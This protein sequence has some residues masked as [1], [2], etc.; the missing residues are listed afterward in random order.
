MFGIGVPELLLILAIALIV[1]G[2]K[3]L[4]DLA[5]SMGRAM[6]EFKKATGEI[7]ESLSMD[8]DLNDVKEAFDDIK[9]DLKHSLDDPPKRE[10]KKIS[11]DKKVKTLDDTYEEWIKQ[12]TE[13]EPPSDLEMTDDQ[14][15]ETPESEPDV[16][17]NDPK[18]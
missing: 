6:R 8:A 3:K 9:G 7:K 5:K 1:I 16:S 15:I 14:P 18:K 2:P 11:E 12:K 13:S 10:E 4:P 17:E